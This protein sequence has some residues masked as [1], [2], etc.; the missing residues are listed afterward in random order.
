M[1]TATASL[2][3][4]SSCSY[5]AIMVMGPAIWF[6]ALNFMRNSS[7]E[8]TDIEEARRAKPVRCFL[9]YFNAICRRKQNAV[10][11]RTSGVHPEERNFPMRSGKKCPVLGA[12]R[13]K[14]F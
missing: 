12:K 11:G 8:K 14:I 3:T 2:P 7:F 4:A 13:R 6:L 9:G 5:T 10:S 1:I